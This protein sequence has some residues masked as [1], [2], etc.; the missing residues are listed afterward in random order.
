MTKKLGFFFFSFPLGVCGGWVCGGGRGGR[1][2][3]KV[4]MAGSCGLVMA[5][6]CHGISLDFNVT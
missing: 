3:E 2:V 1:R 5:T 4:T 6:R